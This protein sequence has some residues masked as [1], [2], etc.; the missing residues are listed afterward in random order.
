MD[1]SPDNFEA[2][3]KLLRLKRH[4]Q[5]PPRYFNDFSSRILARIEAGQER[6]SWWDR[7]GI[8]LRPAFAAGIGVL[9]CGLVVYGVATA[10]GDDAQLADSLWNG[11]LAAGTALASGH[12]L[13]MDAEP[14]MTANS[15]NPVPSYGTPVDR[16]VFGGS[17]TPVS[18]PLR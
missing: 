5:P 1:S 6:A 16:K 8:D 2:L 18:F 10:G 9:A 15:T 7:F 3:E 12:G 4:E 14:T 17:A 13:M 11:S